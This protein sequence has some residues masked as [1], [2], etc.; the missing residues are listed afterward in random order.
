M[1]TRKPPKSGP[2]L[3]PENEAFLKR[4][5]DKPLDSATVTSVRYGL[6]PIFQRQNASKLRQN[7]LS[8]IIES[9]VEIDPAI[10]GNA[11][12]AKLKGMVG[13]GVV[14]AVTDDNIEW[15]T[16][17]EDDAGRALP[18]RIKDTPITAVKDRVYRAKKRLRQ[19]SN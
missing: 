14:T 16:R 13:N 8:E 5:H 4:L 6:L 12:I 2:K 3:H 18:I 17:D 15:Q 7:A 9:L 11:V 19:K 10:T 1:P